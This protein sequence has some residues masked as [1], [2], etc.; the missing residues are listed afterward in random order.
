MNPYKIA[1]YIRLSLEDAKTDSMSIPNQRLIIRQKAEAL[2]EW[3]YAETQEFVDNGYSGTNFERPAMQEMLALIQDGKIDCV[4]VKDF[5]RFGRNSIETGFF[6]ERVFPVYHTRFISIND[7]YDSAQH[8][9]DTGGMDAAFRYLINEAY[10]R[11]LSVKN[12]SARY[13]KMR[14]GEFQSAICPYG[15]RKSADGRME[16]NEET[17]PVIKQIFQLAAEGMESAVIARKLTEMKIPTPGE[18]RATHTAMKYSA[19]NIRGIWSGSTVRT[20]LKDER[21][22]GT[23]VMG[24]RIIR[25][26]GSGL[27]QWRD[28]SEW[29]KIPDHHPAIVGK[30][31]FQ[32]AQQT[33]RH[34]PHPREQRHDYPL[35]G[36]VFCGYCGHALSRCNHGQWAKYYCRHSVGHPDRPCYELRIRA[37]VLE[38]AVLDTLKAHVS[39][40]TGSG[41]ASDEIPSIIPQ[42]QEYENSRQR[43]M[44]AKCRLYEQYVEGS[45]SLESFQKENS[46]YNDELLQIGNMLAAL[47]ERKKRQM[48]AKEAG[49]RRMELFRIVQEAD[50]LSQELA[51]KVI[52]KV[53]VYH[54]AH[55]EIEYSVRDFFNAEIKDEHTERC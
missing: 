23:Y 2:A 49:Q 12:R 32:K 8:P 54:G 48:D 24:K 18:Y 22:T 45:I 16:P 33:R 34:I 43:L 1:F 9:G 5:S 3:P 26:V 41:F 52:R 27:I 7:G 6:I 30:E 37:S 21:Y 25:E 4:I 35:R 29:F 55:I 51:E 42:E 46:A 39:V 20:I 47:R 11:D 28:E 15:Y 38:Q 40:L 53:L 31:L 14:R 13:A 10:S 44:E 50:S 19:E 17:A 36:K